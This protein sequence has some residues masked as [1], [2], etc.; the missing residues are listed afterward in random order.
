MA[1]QMGMVFSKLNCKPRWRERLPEL[2][3]PVLVVHGQQDP[4]FPVGNG[5]VLARGGW[6]RHESPSRKGIPLRHAPSGNSGPARENRKGD[7]RAGRRHGRAGAGECRVG[8]PARRAT[9][10]SSRAVVCAAHR[11]TRD[12]RLSGYDGRVTVHD[13]GAEHDVLSHPGA[14]SCPDRLAG[15]LAAT[16]LLLG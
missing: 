5:E 10:T 12:I 14:S 11:L 8:D 2:A 7:R 16:G 4:F 1:S 13:E 6:P 9:V 15:F 3:I